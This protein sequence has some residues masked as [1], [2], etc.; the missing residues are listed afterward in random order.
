MAGTGSALTGH[1]SDLLLN[2][3]ATAFLQG[4]DA[5]GEYNRLDWA[6]EY[7][8]SAIGVPVLP[9]FAFAVLSSGTR[10]L[11]GPYDGRDYQ[12]GLSLGGLV[13]KWLGIGANLKYIGMD[14]HEN[15]LADPV[16]DGSYAVAADAG[17]LFRLRTRAGNPSLAL[18]LRNLGTDMR[19]TTWPYYEPLPRLLS[20]GAAWSVTAQDFGRKWRFPSRMTWLF[21]R[22]WLLNNLGMSVAYDA[23]R[24]LFRWDVLTHCAGAELRLVPFIAM[25]MG[26]FYQQQGYYT[27]KHSGWTWGLGLDLKFVRVDFS[28]DYHAPGSQPA[29]RFSFALNIG[30]PL[31][32]PGGL[33]DRRD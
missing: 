11:E 22:E 27:L 4:V 16:S 3:A 20:L 21:S 6:V 8:S 29:Y 33:F 23:H 1:A 28:D 30:E 14:W 5:Y 26:Y 15:G 9:R 19:Y 7:W 25:R 18:A 10:F 12:A 17:L 32:R 24:G 31:V 2:P 13:A